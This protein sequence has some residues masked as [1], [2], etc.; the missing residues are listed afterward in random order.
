MPFETF[1]FYTTQ[2]ALKRFLVT[3][4]LFPLPNSNNQN[5]SLSDDG[6][7]HLLFWKNEVD[8]DT[9]TSFCQTDTNDNI[10]VLRALLPCELA[11]AADKYS[12]VQT[13][14]QIPFFNVTDIL[15]VTKPMH[16]LQGDS[17]LVI[18][19]QL[20]HDSRYNPT[21]PLSPDITQQ[22]IAKYLQHHS[23]TAIDLDDEFEDVDIS[24]LEQPDDIASL[25]E[26]IDVTQ[27]LTAGYLMFMQ[28]AKPFDYTLSPQL[29]YSLDGKV[30]FADFVRQAVYTTVPIDTIKAYCEKLD[31]QSRA[32][33]SALKNSQ[34][35]NIDRIVYSA[36]IGALLQTTCS[37]QDKQRFLQLFVGD[38]PIKLQPLVNETFDDKRARN[39]IATL[40]ST[41]R[42]LVPIYF[43]Y[44]FWDYRFDRFCENMTEFGLSTEFANV[45][46][47]LWALLHGMDDVY[48]E[49]KNIEL[50]YA[51]KSLSITCDNACRKIPYTDFAQINNIKQNK[52][53]KVATVPCDYVNYEI[54]YHYCVD[55][56][57]AEIDKLLDEL[58][59]RLNDTFDFLY[60]DLRKRIC[61]ASA[62]PVTAAIIWKNR[63]AI[64]KKFTE[65][66]RQSTPVKL[67]R[68]R[69][70]RKNTTTTRQQSIFDNT[71]E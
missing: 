24:T 10:I 50:L 11:S 15:Y 34:S 48:S 30:S 70:A 54:E 47:S 33:L 17:T 23:S 9:L 26:T 52:K 1:Y 21:S 58:K 16:F 5:S 35:D 68:K 49:Y 22:A 45:T 59:C 71:E 66:S 28:G 61:Y 4:T 60:P 12:I 53:I 20:L 40:K 46:L 43:L 25:T 13:N 63:V 6:F 41:L 36:A 44:T 69:T 32:Y 55:E 37:L 39:R 29:Y 51:I 14:E 42:S 18:P 64:H 56:K 3:Y 31:A 7:G 19:T 65:M 57:S 8:V 2:N 38:L 27:R 62:Q 67:K